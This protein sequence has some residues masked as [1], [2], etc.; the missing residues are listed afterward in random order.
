MAEKRLICINCPL[1]CQLTVARDGEGRLT[2]DGN[3]CQKGRDYGLQ[4]I[5]EPKRVL[6]C[7]VRLSNRSIPLSV[8]TDI[9]IPKN[10][11]FNCLNEIYEARPGAPVRIGD[12]ILK[13]VCNTK[14]N[15]IA[16]KSIL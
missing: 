1:S 13:N 12:V 6:T 7:L 5:T 8:K 16:T 4:E 9:P 2:V 11:L 14:A 3:G 15:V 10:L